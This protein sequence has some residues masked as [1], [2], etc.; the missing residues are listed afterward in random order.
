[1]A[2]FHTA[3]KVAEKNKWPFFSLETSTLTV[4]FHCAC[5]FTRLRFKLGHFSLM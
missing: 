3:Y 5:L 4:G 1:M 2:S